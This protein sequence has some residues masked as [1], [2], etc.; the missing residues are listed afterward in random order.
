MEHIGTFSSH[1]DM[2]ATLKKHA[3]A[4]HE[5]L[6]DEQRGLNFG[7]KWV[8]P[9]EFGYE[10]GH[11]HTPEQVA[12]DELTNGTSWA[13]TIGVVADIGNRFASGYMFGT[14][15]SILSVEGELGTTHKA[16]VW[17][18]DNETFL[19][20][21]AAGWDFGVIEERALP[22]IRSAHAHLTLHVRVA[23]AR[24]AAEA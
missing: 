6:A 7:D 3:D 9:T 19:A 15:Y 11:I 8:R 24:E 23:A 14:A 1:E 5:G 13:D 12:L 16:V 20:A 21:K 4:A 17:P 2:L 18:I 22:A 10:F